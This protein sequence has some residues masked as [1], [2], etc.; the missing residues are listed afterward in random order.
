MREGWL[1]ERSDS[2]FEVGEPHR[3]QVHTIVQHPRSTCMATSRTHE[4][5][6]YACPYCSG[7]CVRQPG[8]AGDHQCP[9]GHNW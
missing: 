5:C 4:A 1:A 8:H 7:E 9:N 6:A 2:V 3:A